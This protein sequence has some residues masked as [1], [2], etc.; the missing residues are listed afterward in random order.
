MIKAI[1]MKKKNNISKIKIDVRL[2][3]MKMSESMSYVCVCA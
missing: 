1:H 3:K 2:S